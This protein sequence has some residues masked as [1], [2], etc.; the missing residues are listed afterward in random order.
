[1]DSPL[2]VFVPRLGKWGKG[3][4]GRGW[5]AGCQSGLLWK[6]GRR[7]CGRGTWLCRWL[8]SVDGAGDG[9][10]DGAAA[11]A[12]VSCRQAGARRRRRRRRDPSLPSLSLLLRLLRRRSPTT[13]SSAAPLPPFPFLYLGRGDQFVLLL[14]NYYNETLL[15]QKK[16]TEILRYNAKYKI[17][18]ISNTFTVTKTFK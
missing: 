11:A 18:F 9:E 6:C 8:A 17:L 13:V 16:S 14:Y 3:L 2:F 4:L 12:A 15:F 5:V 1:M 7:G 10:D